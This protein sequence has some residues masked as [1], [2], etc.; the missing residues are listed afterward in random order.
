MRVGCHPLLGIVFAAAVAA[1]PLSAARDV[2]QSGGRRARAAGAAAPS[3]AGSQRCASGF[4]ASSRKAAGGTLL[5]ME[6]AGA[7]LV[8]TLDLHDKS[9]LVVPLERL[10]VHSLL[11]RLCWLLLAAAVC[12]DLEL[13]R[14]Q[15]LLKQYIDL[16]IY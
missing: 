15:R 2:R 16:Y 6:A 7:R 10:L 9:G 13:L 1:N 3:A 12:V 11:G 8:S 5:L 14:A 4:A